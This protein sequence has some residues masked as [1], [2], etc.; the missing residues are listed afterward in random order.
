MTFI[1][2]I[3]MSISLALLLGTCLLQATPTWAKPVANT[4]TM[5]ALPAILIAQN[6]VETECSDSDGDG[7][8]DVNPPSE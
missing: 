2:K 3:A 8:C 4:D 6:D 5:R 1:I 7:E